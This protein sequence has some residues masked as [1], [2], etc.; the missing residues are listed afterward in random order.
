MAI[1]LKCPRCARPYS[2]AESLLGRRVRCKNCATE[3]LVADPAAGPP[4]HALSPAP[5]EPLPAALPADGAPRRPRR[6]RRPA[7]VPVWAWVVGGSVV[8]VLFLGV[9]AA[10]LFVVFHG[11]SRVTRANYARLRIGMTEGEVRAILGAPTQSADAGS[12]PVQLPGFGSMRTLVWKEGDRAITVMFID[13]RAVMLGSQN[14]PERLN[15]VPGAH[16]P[17]DSSQNAAPRPGLIWDA[18]RHAVNV[19]LRRQLLSLE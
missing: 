15:G 14:L 3:F 18:H 13:D 5:A 11:G 16:G 8:L 17:G 2:V 4:E 7:G 9:G 12:L 10:L 19:A 6:A 1:A